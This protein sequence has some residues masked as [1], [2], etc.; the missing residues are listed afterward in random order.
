MHTD[1]ST[2]PPTERAD[3]ELVVLAVLPAAVGVAVRAVEPDEQSAPHS[4]SRSHSKSCPQDAAEDAR[5]SAAAVVVG[6]RVVLLLLVLV[7]VLQW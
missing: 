7:L 2:D 5:V 3:G 6:E 1:R 4:R